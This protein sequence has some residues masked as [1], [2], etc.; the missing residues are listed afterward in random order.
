MGNGGAED[1]SSVSSLLGSATHVI[2]IRGEFDSC[3]CFK[4]YFFMKTKMDLLPSAFWD[5]DVIKVHCY[6]N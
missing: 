4:L 5:S 3:S 2:L 6:S 1:K